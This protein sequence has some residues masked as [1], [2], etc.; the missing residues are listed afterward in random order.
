MFSLQTI[1]HK[2]TLVSNIDRLLA[3]AHGQELQC[4]CRT[5]IDKSYFI[6]YWIF[7]KVLLSLQGE[8][9]GDQS[10]R[11]KGR[12]SQLPKRCGK[13]NTLKSPQSLIV[14]N[15]DSLL[16]DHCLI[17]FLLC[18]ISTLCIMILKFWGISIGDIVPYIN[19]PRA[20]LLLILIETLFFRA[21]K[22]GGGGGVKHQP[23]G[24][25]NLQQ[26]LKYILCWT[27]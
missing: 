10:R 17:V 26:A 8:T 23:W 5:N 7:I 27:S 9:A 24:I 1:L 4:V 6:V 11:H 15:S 14:T 16:K 20:L 13:E 25:T 21:V 18:F 19:I 12:R 3:F 22:D 2:K